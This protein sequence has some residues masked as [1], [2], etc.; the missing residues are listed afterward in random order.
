[1]G[2][3]N[4]FARNPAETVRFHKLSELCEITLFYAEEDQK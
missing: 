3:F 1:M 4:R 2:I